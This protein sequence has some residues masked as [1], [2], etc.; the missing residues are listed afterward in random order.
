ML[1]KAV[2]R[3][4]TLLRTGLSRTIKNRKPS[5]RVLSVSKWMVSFAKLTSILDEVSDPN[6][7]LSKNGTKSKVK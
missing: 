4:A 7:K 6:T 1:E 3:I 2:L 5:P